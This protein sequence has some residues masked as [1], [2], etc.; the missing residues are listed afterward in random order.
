[1]V[2]T[3]HSERWISLQEVCEYL[4]V[5]H[6]TV[7]HWIDQSGVSAS[8]VGEIWPFKAADIDEWVKKDG[9]SVEL[10]IIK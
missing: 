1:M 3:I 8:K 9:T 6:N 10:E 4:G 2:E 5:K 7:I